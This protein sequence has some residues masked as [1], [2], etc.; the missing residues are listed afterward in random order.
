MTLFLFLLPCDKFAF[1]ARVDNPVDDLYL[2]L[3]VG[4]CAAAA[5]FACPAFACLPLARLSPASSHSFSH[6]YLLSRGC[7][8]DSSS[9]FRFDYYRHL[10]KRLTWEPGVIWLELSLLSLPLIEDSRWSPL[11]SAAYRLSTDSVLL[12]PSDYLLCKH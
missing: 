11:H 8:V 6:D 1:S 4:R 7:F 9:Y 10:T 2:G 5:L 3:L 12:C